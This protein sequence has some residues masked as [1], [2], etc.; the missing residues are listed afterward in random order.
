MGAA[1]ERPARQHVKQKQPW[2]RAHQRVAFRRI[3]RATSEAVLEIARPGYRGGFDGPPAQP[4]ARGYTIAGLDELET[5]RLIEIAQV[6]PRWKHY[7]PKT[8]RQKIVRFIIGSRSWAARDT[9]L[10]RQWLERL[11]YQYHQ[12]KAYEDDGPSIASQNEAL[13]KLISAATKFV[14]ALEELDDKSVDRLASKLKPVSA[15]DIGALIYGGRRAA[16]NLK[17][18]AKAEFKLRKRE[19]WDHLRAVGW[20]VPQLIAMYEAASGEEFSADWVGKGP[21]LAPVSKGTR[22]IWNAALAIDPEVKRTA[23]RS[24]C[25]RRV[26]K[27]GRR[28]KGQ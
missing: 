24:C 7:K 14:E 11:G 12:I 27:I 20:L 17:I 25:V 18:I 21:S 28:L 22:F 15:V 19:G 2:I 1:R 10:F 13:D 5:D 26:S 3:D 23:L 9:E 16:T 8:D 6:F 4:L